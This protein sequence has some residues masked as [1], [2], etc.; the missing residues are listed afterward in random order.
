[1]TEI[2]REQIKKYLPGY[3]NSD[4]QFLKFSTAGSGS[5]KYNKVIFLAFVDGDANPFCCVKTVRT[6]KENPI[7][8]GGF[9]NLQYLNKLT[10]G[11][12]FEN[13]FPKVIGLYN[14]GKEFIFSIESICGGN[15]MSTGAVDID[16]I[17]NKYFAFQRH[18]SALSKEYIS[19]LE[20]F[21]NLLKKFSLSNS[22][23]QELNSY[24]FR[25]RKNPR[26]KI[27]LIPQHGDFTLDNIFVNGKDIC[28]VDCDLFGCVDIAGFDLF[29]FLLRCRQNDFVKALERFFLK[30]RQSINE[31]N[32]FF[33]D[34]IIFLYY[35]NDLLI[36]SGGEIGLNAKDIIINFNKLLSYGK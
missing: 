18:I 17:L 33:D 8:S 34:D 5:G 2:F 11:S 29:H 9:K 10:V 32:L 6:Y 25:L 28:V 23:V 15:K 12:V 27:C 30:Y 21:N 26:D 16:L 13:I 31:Q 4:I 1:M 3:K 24:F 19:I 22:D 20:Y 14:D 35:L 7:I 36:K